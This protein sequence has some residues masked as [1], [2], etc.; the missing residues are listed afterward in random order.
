MFMVRQ[1][2]QIKFV[3]DGINYDLQTLR[4][5]SLLEES[6]FFFSKRIIRLKKIIA[7]HL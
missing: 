5:I 6:D 3:I 7:N 1:I 4:S 2:K